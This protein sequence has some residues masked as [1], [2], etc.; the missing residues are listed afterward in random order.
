MNGR[1]FLFIFTLSLFLVILI[2]PKK[3]TAFEFD[4]YNMS[5]KAQDSQ[6]DEIIGSKKTPTIEFAIISDGTT[7]IEFRESAKEDGRGNWRVRFH[8]GRGFSEINWGKVEKIC[9]RFSFTNSYTIVEECIVPNPRLI[10]NGDFLDH[11]SSMTLSAYWNMKREEVFKAISRSQS[12]L[13]RQDL[14]DTEN[15]FRNYLR[16]VPDSEIGDNEINAMLRLL[17]VF[18]RQ[19]TALGFSDYFLIGTRANGREI[20]KMEKAIEED[21]ARAWRVFS[22]Y[23]DIDIRHQMGF[24]RPNV[25]ENYLR[26]SAWTLSLS[27]PEKQLTGI[28]MLSQTCKDLNNRETASRCM[29][30]DIL[31]Q[32]ID[33]MS[34][35][36]DPD[37]DIRIKIWHIANNIAFYSNCGT[38]NPVDTD[39][40]VFISRI[41]ESLKSPTNTPS[42]FIDLK[43]CDPHMEEIIN[44]N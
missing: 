17:E 40:L 39:V 31:G 44:D 28:R 29:S 23:M 27:P 5:F 1:V 9:A 16:D 21:P 10:S 13:S 2:I 38:A 11:R 41:T 25:L 35:M 43:K 12:T 36:T 4:Y 19:E 18:D 24:E 20:R 14:A 8:H 42:I 26:A 30:D 15:M 33:A 7:T 37:R 32:F 3:S 22:K 34:G 6:F